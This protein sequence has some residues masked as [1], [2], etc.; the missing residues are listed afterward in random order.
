MADSESAAVKENLLKLWKDPKFPASFSGLI[1]F[2][3]ALKIEKNINLSIKQLRE[4]MRENKMYLMH[5][6]NI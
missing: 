2:Q 3:H 4:I 5:Q 1:V 6:G